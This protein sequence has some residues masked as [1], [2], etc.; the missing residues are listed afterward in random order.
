MQFLVQL[1]IRYYKFLA[2]LPTGLPLLSWLTSNN[3]GLCPIHTEKHLL[4]SQLNIVLINYKKKQSG[5][6][7]DIAVQR[8]EN[9]QDK[10]LGQLDKYQSLQNEINQLWKIKIMVIPVV[11]SV[12]GVIADTLPG[13][14]AKT[15]RTVS[16]V[17][18]H[19]SALLKRR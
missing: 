12:L 8:D 7:I 15:P 9:I 17:E 10:K 16:E 18:L 4:K 2:M 5:V 13:W 3:G 14:L 1:L 6:I 19:K 11:M